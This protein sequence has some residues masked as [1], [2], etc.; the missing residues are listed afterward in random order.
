MSKSLFVLAMLSIL[1]SVQWAAADNPSF[2]AD[3]KI[4]GEY[5]R[6]HTASTYHQGA[7]RHAETLG[8]YGRR[9]SNV[10]VETTR[11]HAAE[12]VRNLNAAKKELSKLEKEA[13]G[14]KPVEAHLKAI[15][16]HHAKATELAK[17]LEDKSADAKTIA[18]CTANIAKELKAAEAENEKL[19]KTLGI[20]E[21]P[22]KT[23]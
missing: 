18:A 23:K 21:P 8:Y 9:Y 3:R 15:E 14:N 16:S 7:I 19:K 10:P 11:E 22:A 4:T 2:R 17:Q 13:K 6:P 12:I 5:F 1:G 20:V